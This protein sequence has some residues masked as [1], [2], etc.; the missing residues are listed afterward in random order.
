[1]NF[2]SPAPQMTAHENTTPAALSSEQPRT[3]KPIQKSA[4]CA[5]GILSL[6]DIF[7]SICLAPLSSLTSLA[8]L[9]T[10]ASLIL[11]LLAHFFGVEA[12]GVDAAAAVDGLGDARVVVSECKRLTVFS[13]SAAACSG[14]SYTA[15]SAPVVAYAKFCFRGFAD[16]IFSGPG[17][18][19]LSITSILDTR[20][21]PSSSPS[22]AYAVRVRVGLTIP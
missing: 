15:L 20:S 3:P 6:G 2:A 22:L 13:R 12:L 4:K 7:T 21:V 5:T 1:M 18:A 16:S 11:R 10:T 9:G 17:V 19:G 14:I 8:S